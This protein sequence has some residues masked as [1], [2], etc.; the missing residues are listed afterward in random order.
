MS[1]CLWIP[2]LIERSSAA[3]GKPPHGRLT[4]KDCNQPHS[5]SGAAGQ[6]QKLCPHEITKITHPPLQKDSNV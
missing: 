1:G 5:D 3:G 2:L 6:Q 4:A